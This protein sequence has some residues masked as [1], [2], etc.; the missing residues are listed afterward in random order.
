[1]SIEGT[2]KIELLRLTLPEEHA[3]E[4]ALDFY[5]YT[6]KSEVEAKRSAWEDIQKE[7]PRLREFDLPVNS[8]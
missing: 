1:M 6:G 7:F 8:E 5:R 2:M 3:R 4:R